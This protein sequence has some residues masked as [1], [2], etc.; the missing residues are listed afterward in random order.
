MA[1]RLWDSADRVVSVRLVY[2][3]AR[4]A[5]AQAERLDRVGTRD[6]R[7]AVNEL[8][9]RFEEMDLVEIDDSLAHLAGEKAE[10][11]AAP[12][13]TTRCTSRR[14]SECTIPMSSSSRAIVRSRTAASAESLAVAQLP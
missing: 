12:R 6:L 3:E 10:D 9:A 4:A 1:G 11:H 14:R 5:L 13:F 8:D 7:R 2:P